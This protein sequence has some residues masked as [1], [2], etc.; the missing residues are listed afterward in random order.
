LNGGVTYEA[1]VDMRCDGVEASMYPARILADGVIRTLND[2]SSEEQTKVCTGSID[3]MKDGSK[4][5]VFKVKKAS[6]DV[7]GDGG[8]F[9]LQ[10]TANILG[11]DVQLNFVVGWDALYA[12]DKG[13]WYEQ[14]QS[15]DLHHTITFV[16]RSGDK[17]E[18]DVQP[19]INS[20]DYSLALK[21]S[22]LNG[23]VTYEANV[24]MRCDG[25]E[26]SMYPARILADGVIR[27]LNDPSSEEQ[28]KVCTGSIDLMKD[29][30]KDYVF[31]VKKASADL[32][33]GG[34]FELQSTATILGDDVQLDFV[35][36]WD[37]L[38][39]ITKIEPALNDEYKGEW[40]EQPA[41]GLMCVTSSGYGGLSTSTSCID[42][43][44]GSHPTGQPGCT[45]VWQWDD[46]AGIDLH[47]AITFVARSG[48]K[49][50]LAVDPEL[51]FLSD[52]DDGTMTVNVNVPA[53]VQ[54]DGVQYGLDALITCAADQSWTRDD[55]TRTAGTG[56]EVACS[57][58]TMAFKQD[59][60]VRASADLEK[61][62]ANVGW[63]KGSIAIKGSVFAES[64]S[65]NKMY[66]L[67]EY[68]VKSDIQWLGD[69]NTFDIDNAATDNDTPFLIVNPVLI[70]IATAGDIPATVFG[71]AAQ[72]NI[73]SGSVKDVLQQL[74]LS[75]TVNLETSANKRVHISI[76]DLKAITA[77]DSASWY[78]QTPA[79]SVPADA[80][81]GTT[82]APF[83][84]VPHGTAKTTTKHSKGD[85][86]VYL[87]DVSNV[88]VGDTM[89]IGEGRKEESAVVAAVT[90][91]ASR[92]RRGNDNA[93]PGTVTLVTPLQ[94]MHR[95]GTPVT[96]HKT[97]A[98]VVDNGSKSGVSAAAIA[99]PICAVLVLVAAAVL[100]MA[101]KGKSG[102]STYA[103]QSN[104]T[105]SSFDNPTY[106]EAARASDSNA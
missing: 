4:D 81:P 89:V 58:V 11:D 55:G 39:A 41:C 97:V 90:P 75:A 27:T 87:D 104:T 36:G 10:S 102:A 85:F 91:T 48:Q 59:G 94:R 73:P 52:D 101:R 95:S 56:S 54:L 19:K 13:E 67:T 45:P 74:Q 12:L 77:I 18:L 82:D 49:F 31:T 35:V 93:V 37:A 105:P 106:E 38:Y 26:A 43:S 68:S 80:V 92:S 20:D 84:A 5:Y 8:G 57:D 62:V 83:A 98:A 66:E 103:A 47:H 78:G 29:G 42:M 76:G 70:D 51:K 79:D 50:N 72:A 61:V 34:G 65:S 100:F 32:G 63:E 60:Q 14:L 46:L 53:S 28:T 25:V 16:G 7:E 33:D 86:E 3:L 96:F 22:V 64:S 2:P 30:S 15:V 40:Y 6:V 1:N 9:E 23:G 88:A 44:G 21:G 24:D 69:D 17:F 71:M 99:V